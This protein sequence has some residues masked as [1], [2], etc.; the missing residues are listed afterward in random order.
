VVEYKNEILVFFSL[1]FLIPNGCSI[2]ILDDEWIQ[3]CLMDIRIWYFSSI[4][5][6]VDSCIN[7]E[8]F[9]QY[10]FSKLLFTNFLCS[11]R[12]SKFHL[13]NWLFKFKHYPL[14]MTSMNKQSKNIFKIP[15]INNHILNF[16]TKKSLKKTL[17]FNL[18][19][20]VKRNFKF[21]VSKL[22]DKYWWVQ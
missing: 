19:F 3:T 7:F 12:A 14:K 9:V 15:W 21:L 4:K 20:K 1:S 10:R 17:I 11:M 8:K 13:N 2:H 22:S 16:I 6:G 5:I 18:N